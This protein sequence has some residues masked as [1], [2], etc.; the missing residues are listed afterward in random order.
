MGRGKIQLPTYHEDEKR[1]SKWPWTVMIALVTGVI[2]FS[3]PGVLTKNALVLPTS[4]ELKQAC[5]QP[6]P[7]LPRGYNT[8]KVLAEKERVID[9]LSGAVSSGS[10]REVLRGDDDWGCRGS[11]CLRERHRR[12][13]EEIRTE[14]MGWADSGETS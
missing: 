13:V 12:G 3:G 7:T 1:S 5:Y 9:W 10:G 14:G 8:S 2:W 4:D 6:E 11:G